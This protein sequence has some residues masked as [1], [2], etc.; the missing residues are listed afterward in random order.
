[1]R[2]GFSTCDAAKSNGKW[3]LREAVVVLGNG[4]RYRLLYWVY[5]DRWSGNRVKET[6]VHLVQ[7]AR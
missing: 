5:V 4:L 6:K 7:L 1:M 3:A 2:V